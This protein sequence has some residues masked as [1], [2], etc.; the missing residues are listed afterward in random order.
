MNGDGVF[1]D[2]QSHWKGRI[3]AVAVSFAKYQGGA[4]L[5]GTDGVDRRVGLQQVALRLAARMRLVCTCEVGSADHGQSVLIRQEND[6]APKFHFLE[7]GPV[8][9]GLRVAFDLLDEEGHY[10][11]D[12]R[13]D[14][15][16]YPEGD[17]HLTCNMQTVDQMAHGEI[18][19]A[20]LEVRGA[21]TFREIRLGDQILKGEGKVE[22]KFGEQLPDKRIVLA[23]SDGLAALYWARDEGSTWQSKD[24]GSQPPFYASHWPTGMQQWCRG[25]MSWAA[26]GESAGVGAALTDEGP[27]LSLA[28]LQKGAVAEEVTYTAM[29]V[30]S[31]ASDLEELERRIQAVQQPLE[32]RV[33]GGNFRYYTEE[34]GAYEIGQGDPTGVNI[35]FPAD[36]LERQVRLRFYRR[37]TDPRHYGGVVV[38]A[39]GQPLRFQ[40]VSDGELVDDICVPMEMPHRYHSVDDVTMA[41]RLSAG[42]PTEIRIEKVPGIHAAYQ[43]EVTGLDLQRRA[44]NCRDIAIWS[45]RNKEKPAL[46]LDLF[47]MA[48]HRFTACDQSEYAVWEMPMAWFKSC[49]ISKHEYCNHVKEFRVEKNGPDA[50]EIYTRS[51]NPNQRTQ[52]E[53]WLRVPYDH[54]RTR[55]E[56]RMRMEVLEQW[57]YNNAEFTDI[58]PYPSRLVETWFHDAVLFVQRDRNYVKHS[59]RPDLSAGR[60]G[61]SDDDRLFYALYP[62]DRGNVLTLFKNPQHPERELHYSVCGNYIDIHVNLNP[63][64]P[65]V[66]AGTVFEIEYVCELYGDG[67]TSADELRQIGLRSLEAGD[68]V[69]E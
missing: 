49:G 27:T 68:I 30:V 51:T 65:P 8:R 6:P 11:G 34:D 26:G 54:P 40:L 2:C 5:L 7:E 32:P 31:L 58:F 69:V 19:D 38:T 18:Q 22:L 36:P 14:V 25:N 20:C 60:G 29:L 43:T 64:D 62:S 21:D 39:K 4:V 42:E 23:G 45:S 28:W 13:F 66:P 1:V 10:H 63:G 17:I 48:A 57:D 46:E 15:W 41:T 59:F 24:H 47:S 12:G 33:D 3:G 16:A 37:K 67:T 52:S 56:V 44:G 9:I 61:H 35:T 50:V 55:L 53:L